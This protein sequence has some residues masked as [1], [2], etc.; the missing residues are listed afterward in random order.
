MHS[1][2][3]RDTPLG[4]LCLCLSVD[5]QNNDDLLR[6]LTA[7]EMNWPQLLH[8]AGNHL[9]TPTLAYAL[10]RRQILDQLDPEVRDYLEGIQSLN[11]IRNETLRSELLSIAREL[12]NIAITPV[13]I[14]G[15]IALLPEHYPGAT[16]RIMGDLDVVVPDERMNEAQVLLSDM[17]YR[18]EPD[19]QRWQRRWPWRLCFIFP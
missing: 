18:E 2:A 4:L 19:A 6:R 10:Q 7:P 17:G 15:A 13:L 1:D 8:T 12:N 9:V 11:L 3:L 5:E 14:K 16:H